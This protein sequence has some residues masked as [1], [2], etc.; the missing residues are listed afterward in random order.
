MSFSP[1]LPI[2]L[3]DRRFTFGALTGSGPAK[4]TPAVGPSSLNSIRTIRVA[5]VTPLASTGAAAGVCGVEGSGVDT[6]R[7][8]QRKYVRNKIFKH[9]HPRA[10]RTKHFECGIT[11]GGIHNIRCPVDRFLVEL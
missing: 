9:A 8:I 11:S 3:I 7:E 1:V 6:S 10:R 2:R 5:N 4:N